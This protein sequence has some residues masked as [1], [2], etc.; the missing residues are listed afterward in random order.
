MTTRRE[1]EG[2]KWGERGRSRE[3]AREKQGR[4]RA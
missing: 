1:S 3:R 4:T 2:R